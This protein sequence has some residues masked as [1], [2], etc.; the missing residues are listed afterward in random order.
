MSSASLVSLSED[1]FLSICLELTVPDILSLRRVSRAFNAA[2]Q[3]ETLWLDLLDCIRSD[4][5]HVLPKYLK[6]P[7]LLDAATLEALVLRVARLGRKWKEHD[8]CPVNVWRRNLCESITWLRLVDGSWLFVAS[9]DNEVSKISCWDLSLLFQGYAEPVDVSYLPGQVKTAQLEV[10]ETGVILALGLGPN[11]P[12]VHVI[13]LRQHAG[14]HHFAELCRIEGSSHVLMLQGNFLGCALRDDAIVAHIID[15]VANAV[16]DLPP[17][18][19]GLGVPDRMVAPHSIVL[20]NDVVVVIRGNALEIYTQPSRAGRPVY[21]TSIPTAG[22]IWEVVVLDR[23]TLRSSPFRLLVISAAGIEL[24]ALDLDVLGEGYHSFTRH[25]LAPSPSAWGSVAPWY[26][27]VANGTGK[28]ALWLAIGDLYDPAI[29]YPHV[30][31]MPIDAVPS[32]P[33]APLTLWTNDLPQDPALWA[34]PTVDF[35][36]ALGFTVIGNCFGE[37]AIYDPV[38]SHPIQCCGLASDFTH[39]SGPL[40][41]L[42]PLNSIPLELRATPRPPFGEPEPD[43]TLISHWSQDDLG[44][45]SRTWKK[46][47]LSGFDS[48]WRWYT[49]QGERGDTAWLLQHAYGFPTSFIPQAFAR[50]TDFDDL[51]VL[52]RTGNCYLVFN[53][54]DSEDVVQSFP[55][56]HLL[57]NLDPNR[58]HGSRQ[59]CICPTAYTIR[60]VHVGMFSTEFHRR[61]GRN[62]WIEQQQRG[63]RPHNNLVNT[64]SVRPLNY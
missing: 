27:L 52:V 39:Q 1:L 10:Q 13:T 54:G 36:E 56:D 12:A 35:D 38:D 29:N 7:V 51:H 5:E 17:P 42:L 57:G 60:D 48:Y 18:P 14:S 24:C 15:W 2:T 28:R 30:V 6:N 3:A 8:L 25:L 64:L 62:R 49:W 50:D 19:G 47:W 9:S 4:E 44:L 33:Q 45:D 53:H 61:K 46:N 55:L 22:A 43:P 16:Y 20:W 41:P 21:I 34:F 11:S 63:G 58:I 32:A 37:L 59:R 31:S 23:P 26:R 40:P